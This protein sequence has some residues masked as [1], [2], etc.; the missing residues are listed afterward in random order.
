MLGESFFSL[1]LTV[2]HNATNG[3]HLPSFLFIHGFTSMA[4]SNPN[5]VLRQEHVQPPHRDVISINP[6]RKFN[7]NRG[8]LGKYI[9][10]KPHL[11]GFFSPPTSL[12]SV[13]MQRLPRKTVRA[14]IPN[15]FQCQDYPRAMAHKG[16]LEATREIALP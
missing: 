12:D 14:M 8:K 11:H 6:G 7:K 9:T 15:T 16:L 10:N 13:A 3:I 5:D 2:N 4:A 1:S